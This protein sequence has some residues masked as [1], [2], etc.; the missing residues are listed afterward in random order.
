MGCLKPVHGRRTEGGTRLKNILVMATGGTIAS[1]PQED[2]LAP[3]LTGEELVERVPLIDSLCHID[4]VQPMNID[5]T[6]MR[7]RDWMQ[8]ADGLARHYDD[9]DGFV[10][11]HGT[12]TMA[13]TAAALSYLLQGGSKPIV[14]TGSQQPMAAPFTDAKLNL[15]Q[16]LLVATDDA[17]RDVCVVFGGKVIAGTRAHKQRTMSYNAFVSMNFPTL[18]YVRGDRVLW[19]GGRPPREKDLPW[20]R[21]RAMDDRVIVLRLTPEFRPQIFSLL[22]D[23]YDAIILETF[24][25]GGIPDY[26]G[27]AFRRA[28]FDWVDS[29]RTLVLTTQVPEEGLDLGVYEVGRAYS[30]HPGILKGADMSTEALVAKT[31]WALG[32]SKDPDSVRELFLRPVNHDRAEP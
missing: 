21:F 4:V 15:Y 18:A 20:R 13:Y 16:S 32:Q 5:S 3:G 30:N 12:D 29:G 2:G 10:V 25:I 1:L 6:N 31:M 26:D 27:D 24:G 11:L 22:K 28:I 7:P 14:L 19:S 9:Y 23:D 17:A 8:I